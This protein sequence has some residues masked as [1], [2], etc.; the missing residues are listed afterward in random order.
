MLEGKLLFDRRNLL[1]KVLQEMEPSHL[2]VVLEQTGFLTRSWFPF[3]LLI[4]EIVYDS[5]AD[6]FDAFLQKT[7]ESLE[8][9]HYPK[10]KKITSAHSLNS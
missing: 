7:K 6:E 5:P 1:W 8:A 4:N 3:F 10:E 9:L 2:K